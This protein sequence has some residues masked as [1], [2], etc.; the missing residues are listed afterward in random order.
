MQ[1][2]LHADGSSSLI[3][4]VSLFSSGTPGD[5]VIDKTDDGR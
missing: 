5:P 3:F 1:A 2:G 4:A